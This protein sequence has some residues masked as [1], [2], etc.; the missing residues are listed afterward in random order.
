M[1][2]T[3]LNLNQMLIAILANHHIP[4]SEHGDY[5]QIDETD[6]MMQAFGVPHLKPPNTGIL[7]QV[8]V[9][10]QRLLGNRTLLEHFSEVGVSLDDAVQKA[11]FSFSRSSLHVILSVFVNRDLGAEQA[12]W[13]QWSNG[14]RA[15]DVCCGPVTPKSLP[16]FDFAHN[17]D[18]K[19]FTSFLDALRDAYL[20]EASYGLH[21]LRY[22]RGSLHGQCIAREV[23]LD[24]ATWKSGEDILD[25]SV[26]PAGPDFYSIRQFF[27]ASPI[28]KNKW[29]FW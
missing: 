26:W 6:V 2:E 27:I 22:Y 17:Y 16:A 21:W 14:E 5:I 13:E 7:L 1:E 20:R 19:G 18:I 15:W 25:R 24:N 4:L 8:G 12:W 3:N 28:P 29:K 11:F 23:L 9:R 10:S